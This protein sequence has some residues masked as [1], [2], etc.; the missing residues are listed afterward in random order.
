MGG[1]Y[2]LFYKINAKTDIQSRFLKYFL[3]KM[4]YQYRVIFY[5]TF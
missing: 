1:K 3:Y 2:Q 4:Q 5:G